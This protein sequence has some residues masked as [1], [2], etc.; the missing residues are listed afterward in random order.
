MLGPLASAEIDGLNGA[1]F[2][3]KPHGCG[4]QT[5]IYTAPNV[6]IYKYLTSIK[7]DTGAIEAKAIQHMREGKNG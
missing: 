2:L 3:G 5:M 7:Q 1:G 4:E 6:Y